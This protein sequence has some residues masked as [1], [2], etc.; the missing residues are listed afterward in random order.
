MQIASRFYDMLYTEISN[1][2]T[3]L[4]EVII[5]ILIALEIVL[6]LMGKM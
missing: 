4:L 3:E 6:F 2:R 5:I 1:K